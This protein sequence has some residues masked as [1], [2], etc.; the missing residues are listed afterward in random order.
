LCRSKR[1]WVQGEETAHEIPKALASLLA[2]PPALEL[3]LCD[4]E[5]EEL[6]SRQ[7]EDRRIRLHAGLGILLRES[8]TQEEQQVWTSLGRRVCT[9]YEALRVPQDSNEEPQTA[10]QNESHRT[11]ED[12]P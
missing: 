5:R 11:G 7:G 12:T 8:L 10:P 2:D 1:P 9:E 6:L 4:L 3:A